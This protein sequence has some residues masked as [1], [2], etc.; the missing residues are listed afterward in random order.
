MAGL[1]YDA[2]VA[3]QTATPPT[4]GQQGQLTNGPTA[5]ANSS[6]GMTASNYTSG[7]TGAADTA[8]VNA[9]FP[10]SGGG[11]PPTTTTGGITPPPPTPVQNSL[12]TAQASGPAPQTQ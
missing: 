1:S 11:V 12:T 4:Y 2:I 3:N 7:L 6:Q 9:A 5:T 8:A 10:S